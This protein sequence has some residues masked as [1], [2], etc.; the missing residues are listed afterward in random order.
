MNRMTR[1]PTVALT[2]SQRADLFDA[3]WPRR[4]SSCGWHSIEAMAWNGWP[5]LDWRVMRP[6]RTDKVAS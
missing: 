5:R 1:R 4:A 2:L 6:R 3:T